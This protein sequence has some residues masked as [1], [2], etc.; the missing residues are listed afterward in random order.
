MRRWTLLAGLL[1][2]C[3]LMSALVSSASGFDLYGKKTSYGWTLTPAG[4][5]TQ[6]GD[7]PMNGVVSP[8]GRYLIVSNDGLLIQSL[9]VVDLSTSRVVQT[10]RYLPPAALYLGLAFSPDGSTLYAS[11][12]GN[13]KIRTFHFASGQLSKEGSIALS[14]KNYYPA[15]LAISRDGR[16]LYVVNNL[17][18]SVSKLDTVTRKIVSTTPVGHNPYG[19]VLSQDGSKLYVSNWGESSVTIVN[20]GTFQT[21][22]TVPVGL[23]PNA[24]TVNPSSGDVFVSN[25]DSDDISI[26]SSVNDGV[27]GTV[28]L[29]PYQQAPTGSQPDALVFTHDGG[30]LYVA[31]AGDNDIAVLGFD[32]Q[33]GWQVNG[34]IPTAWYPTA[35]FLNGQNLIVLNA[36][37]LGAGPNPRYLPGWGLLP[38]GQYIGS[39]ITGTMS[40]IPLPGSLKL[41]AYTQQVQQNDRFL[42]QIG[43][44]DSGLPIQHVIYVIKENRTYDQV[45]GDIS[46]G[47][48]DPSLTEF[49]ASITPN[50]HA[51]AQQFVLFDRCYADAEVSA[52]GHNWSTAA[53]SNDYVE[54]N[55]PANYSY[56]GRPEDFYGTNPATYP[57]AG[58]LWDAAQR[59]G[60]SYRDYGEFASYDQA[61]GVWVPDDP[62]IGNNLDPNYPGW[63]LN[64]SDLTRFDA[65]QQ[66]FNTYVQNG[67]LPALEILRFPNDHTA[68]AFPGKLTPQAYAAQNDQAVGK[69]VQAVSQSPYWQNTLILITEDDAQDGP[70]HVDAHRTEC[71]A[72]SPYTQH[73]AVDHTFYDTAAMVRTIEVFLG[74][75]PMTQFDAAAVP[76]LPAFA[77]DPDFSAYD[78]RPPQTSL[79]D[80]NTWSSPGAA[81]SAQMDFSQ[82]DIAPMGA[83]NRAIW[84]ATM[85]DTPYPENAGSVDTPDD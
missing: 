31:N 1:A 37:G 32:S 12:G 4:H 75:D 65:W 78:A 67:N 28:S 6:L 55:W 62:S 9:Q 72:I 51:L 25:S 59:A 52:Q 40:T 22:R 81:E 60:V 68:G 43:S 23:H 66:E 79:T 48:G 77:G 5:Q 70:D 18:D 15:G 24:M 50:L 47:D 45:F 20:T 76:M 11:A 83:L 26:I 49:G 82:E 7:F 63:D 2:V 30:T 53:K 84:A 69:L 17:D 35:V 56:R 33:G 34:L 57:E 21:R 42:Q 14:G 41:W 27:T 16:T 8:D 13:N 64:I 44:T 29:A 19:A 74:I 54:K 10:I 58:F 85:G 73:Q 46:S 61:S 39:M 36:K 80:T 71:L 3:T 38:P